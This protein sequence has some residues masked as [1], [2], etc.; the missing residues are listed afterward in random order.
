M[1][2]LQSSGTPGTNQIAQ[3]LKFLKAAGPSP[4]EYFDRLSCSCRRESP[5]SNAPT[6]RAYPAGLQMFATSFSN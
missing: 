2:S 5:C 3:L 6:L 4:A 1:L